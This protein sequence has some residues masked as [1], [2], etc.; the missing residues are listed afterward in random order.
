[1]GFDIT[2]SPRLALR[3]NI[4]V[5]L[6]DVIANL[7]PESNYKNQCVSMALLYRR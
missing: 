3:S 7:D 1:M 5:G 2:L 6:R 4:Y